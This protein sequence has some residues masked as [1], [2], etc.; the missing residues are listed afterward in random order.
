V[1]S[2]AAFGC[3][4]PTLAQCMCL[5]NQEIKQQPTKKQCRWG[6]GYLRQ[7]DATAER[8]GAFLCCFGPVKYV[9]P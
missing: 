7:D 8:M 9:T 2:A 6:E 1:A 3:L 4:P 5:P